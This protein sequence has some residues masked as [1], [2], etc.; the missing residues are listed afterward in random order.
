MWESA[1][2]KLTLH[3][4]FPTSP[5]VQQT[6]SRVTFKASGF[7]FAGR[8]GVDAHSHIWG[9]R[10][11]YTLSLVPP[12]PPS[13]CKS[14]TG[15]DF[16]LSFQQPYPHL[17]REEERV[18]GGLLRLYD[19]AQCRRCQLPPLFGWE[20]E[21]KAWWRS[22]LGPPTLSRQADPTFLALK[23]KLE[24]AAWPSG[25]QWP[26]L[27]LLSL[28]P[29]SSR[30]VTKLREWAACSR[31]LSHPATSNAC[32]RPHR[33]AALSLCASLGRCMQ[34]CVMADAPRPSS[35][36][37]SQMWASWLGAFALQPV[38]TSPLLA[39]VG[40]SLQVMRVEVLLE[41]ARERLRPAERRTEH[42]RVAV[43]G[44]AFRSAET[45]FVTQHCR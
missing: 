41:V 12:L 18:G 27:P 15:A 28:L 19:P 2:A 40:W 42:L 1:N 26:S 45:P 5:P 44:H 16:S 33:I 22:N 7:M 13:L 10:F 37:P 32:P 23:S 43:A 25:T 39:N 36:R 6:Q 14:E 9:E 30:L 35:A 11:A 34:C 29:P 3:L 38:A 17:P 21:H 31:V 20:D 8:R 4:H 24:V